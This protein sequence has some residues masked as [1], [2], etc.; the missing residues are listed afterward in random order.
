MHS[1]AIEWQAGGVT[2]GVQAME[3]EWGTQ[4]SPSQGVDECWW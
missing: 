2:G 1:E 3:T 4:K